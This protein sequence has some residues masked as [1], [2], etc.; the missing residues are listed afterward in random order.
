MS[1][2]RDYYEVL[3]VSRDAGA[4]EIKKA[5]RKKAMQYHPDRNPDDAEAE[6]RFKECAEA[7]EVLSDQQK[8]QLY[9]QFG[10]EGPRGAGFQGFSGSEEIFSHFGDLFGDLFGNLGFGGGPRR[11]GGP[12]RGADLKMLLEIPFMEAVEGSER[13]ISVAKRVECDTCDGSGAAPGT[14]PV[15]CTECGGRGQVIHS[16]GFF[17]VQT[18]C[19]RC[20]G[21][22]KMIETPCGDCSGSGTV[23]KESTLTVRIPAGIDEGQTLRVPGGGQ[24][25]AQG[26]PPGN[27]Y[28]VIRVEPDERFEREEYDIFS[29][30]EISMFQATLGTK[31]TID[32]L[33]GE[34]E[35]EI[36]AGTQPETIITRRGKGIPVL[37]GRGKGDHHVRV[38]VTVPKKLS[39]EQ[40]DKLRALAQ[41]LGLDVAARKKG[42]LG[43][44]FG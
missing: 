41:E 1:A 29:D 6:E 5:Y 16:Q 35:L 34:E 10:H 17:R 2:K 26:G 31:V 22:G 3:G 28:V 4:P 40:E 12:Q 36:E 19:P 9:D 23:Q 11:R 8:R 20:R 44:I 30:V 21:A 32:T 7:F 13:E 25:G 33:E 39:G 37:T 24:P 27:L 42:L 43:S 14:S 18:T 38:R 15:A